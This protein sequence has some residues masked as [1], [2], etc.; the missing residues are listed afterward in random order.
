MKGLEKAYHAHGLS[1]KAGISILISDKVDF[2]QKLIR[3]D[4]ER[5]FIL[6]K[7]ITCQQDITIKNI[8]APN[9]GAPMYIKQTLVNFKNQIDHNTIILGDFNTLL[10]PMDRSSKQKPNKED[11]GLMNII[12]NLDITD[13][14]RIFHPLKTEYIFFLAVHRSFSKI[15]NMLCQK[16]A[17]RNIKI[18]ILLCILSEHNGI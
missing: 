5:H 14:Y 15:D 9:S 7:G 8:Y 13:T 6:L 12:N 2:K 10:S 11:T 16:E 18:E 17:I 4:K 3:K 1:K